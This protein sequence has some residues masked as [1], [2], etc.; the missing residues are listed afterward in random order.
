VVAGGVDQDVLPWEHHRVG[1]EASCPARL[2][3]GAAGV[4]GAARA[5]AVRRVVVDA[6]L[7]AEQLRPFLVAVVR[8]EVKAPVAVVEGRSGFGEFGNGWCSAVGRHE[9]APP[10]RRLNQMS[11]S[12]PGTQTFE[13]KPF[14]KPGAR[15]VEGICTGRGRCVMTPT[16]GWISVLN[17]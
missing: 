1:P 8:V 7:A 11:A 5:E 16:G 13:P 10:E 15:K 14:G 4:A 17:G 6:A 9:P 12:M 3:P 2:G